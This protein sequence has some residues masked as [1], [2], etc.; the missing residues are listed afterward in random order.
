MPAIG[1]PAEEES[2][3]AGAIPLVDEPGNSTV[4]AEAFAR[5]AR[6]ADLSLT[7]AGLVSQMYVEEGSEVEADQLLLSLDNSQQLVAV[8]KAKAN[9]SQAQAKLS[10]LTAGSHSEE[11]LAAQAVVQAAK[12]NLASLQHQRSPVDEQAAEAQLRAAEAALNALYRDPEGADVIAATAELRNAQ[13]AVA[14]TQNAYNQVKWRNDAGM[15]PEAENLQEATN[16][17]EAAQA[18]LDLLYREPTP[19]DISQAQA[20]ISEATAELERVRNPT[21][22]GDIEAAEAEVRKAEAEL[23]LLQSGTRPEA[24]AFAQAELD[25]AQAALLE[26]EVAL[27]QTE[28]RAPFNGTVVSLNSEVGEYL[29]PGVTIARIGD[30]TNW[31]FET[32]DLIEL[33]IINV[34]QDAAVRISVDAMPDIDLTGKVLRTRKIGENKVG[35][36]TYTVY[37]EPDRNVPGLAWNMTASVHIDKGD[38]P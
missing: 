18:K 19:N 36:I 29:Q 2:K 32:N 22:A 38:L 25:A 13:A 20:R 14:R 8:A 28:L 31:Q 12:G 3:A 6:K 26:A 27:Q 15:L 5:P 21:K 7:V 33:D 37:I 17:F 10:E 34:A 1:L 30:L 11:I 4:I 23:R 16:N 9:L 24:I 35:D